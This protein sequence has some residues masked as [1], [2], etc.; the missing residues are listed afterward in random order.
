MEGFS[1]ASVDVLGLVEG[2]VAGGRACGCGGRL[3][4][5][6]RNGRLRLVGIKNN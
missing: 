6:Q 4:C 3:G 1:G 5:C 2:S